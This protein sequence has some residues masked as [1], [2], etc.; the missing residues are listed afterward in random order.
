M[1]DEGEPVK[2]GFSRN[3][4]GTGMD[5]AEVHWV[6]MIGVHGMCTHVHVI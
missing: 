2:K 3:R 1:I 4:K 5:Y 6:N